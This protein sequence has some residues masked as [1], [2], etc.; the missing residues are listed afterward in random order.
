MENHNM[1]CDIITSHRGIA[2]L[3]QSSIGKKTHMNHNNISMVTIDRSLSVLPDG[4]LENRIETLLL[5]EKNQFSVSFSIRS[6]TILNAIQLTY[7]TTEFTIYC[8]ESKTEKTN[9]Y[10][11]F[12]RTS[13]NYHFWSFIINYKCGTN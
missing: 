12:T 6:S 2:S 11:T 5:Y 10:A 9:P 4:K 7:S 1:R 13:F 8:T 3:Y